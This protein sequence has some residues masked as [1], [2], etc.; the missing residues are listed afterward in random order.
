[1]PGKPRKR[2]DRLK[3][4]V[5]SDQLWTQ[6]VQQFEATDYVGAEKSAVKLLLTHPRHVQAL[7]L[8]A[9]AAAKLQRPDDAIAKLQQC[10]A[11]DAQYAMGWKDLGSLC[12]TAR[13]LTE[14]ELAL[15]AYLKLKPHDTSA[16]G[17][18]GD[19]LQSDKRHADAAHCFQQGI[20]IQPD[21]WRLYE[22]LAKAYQCE[23]RLEDAIV[24]LQRALAC[25]HCSHDIHRQLV[26]AYRRAGRIAEAA[27]AAAQWQA[28]E[29]DNPT[30]QHMLAAL[31]RELAPDR[32]PD[33]YVAQVFDQFAENFNSELAALGYRAPEL[34]GNV[35]VRAK[36][37]DA[38][39]LDAGCGTGLCG[40]TLR[41]WAV[42]LVGVDLS[43][44][45]LEQAKKLDVYDELLQTELTEY[46]MHC[47]E[48]FDWIISTDTLI[49]FGNLLPV[50]QHAR[51]ALKHHGQL[52]FT[53]EE[54]QLAQT[55]VDSIQPQLPNYRLQ[56]NGR[57]VHRAD[58]V[59]SWLQ[60]VG[61]GEIQITR[62]VLREEAGRPVRGLLI[63]C[64]SLSNRGQH[65]LPGS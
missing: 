58:Q 42:R 20:D 1:M 23:Q 40:P 44:G 51:Q 26:A 65:D 8:A 41:P 22:G 5:S 39:V 17:I 34:V 31:G 7:H 52:I 29:P 54:D 48:T 13:R 25:E 47:Q 46:L 60:Q 62:E 63:H 59:T 15:R 4:I 33:A 21:D 57:Y 14:A 32:A 9:V 19:I 28:L 64:T 61:F 27:D 16:Y 2:P 49:Y 50:L 11:I 30:A 12:Y 10:V 56:P 36:T 45:M 53:L 38:I 6:A 35:V 37:R 18:L 55:S 3:S 43:A 24:V